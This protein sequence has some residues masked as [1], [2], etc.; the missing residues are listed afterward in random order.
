MDS[1]HITQLAGEGSFGR[2]YK[3]RKKFS[4][5]VVALKFIPK[6]GRSA[7]EIQSLKREIDI[8]RDLHHPNIVQLFDSFETE[9]E[10]VVVTEY[11]EGQ[12]VQILEND[13]CLPESRVREIASQLVS[14]L[15]YL[16]SHRILH[17]DMKPQNILLSKNGVVKLCDF[18]F[19]RSMSVSTW[20]LTSI[21][22]T[23]LYMAPELVEEKPYDHTA[24]LWA[25]GCILYELHTG[26]PPFQT[27]SF[28]HL[29]QL[30]VKGSVKWVDNMSDNCK[31][32]LQGLL[33][34]D[35]EKR[36]SWPTLLHH[37][38]VADDIVVV[39]TE[40]SVS[41][42]LTVTPT[43]HMMELKQKQMTALTVPKTGE[44]KLLRKTREMRAMCRA[45]EPDRSVADKP[46]KQENVESIKPA[47]S[48]ASST[49]SDFCDTSIISVM[50]ADSLNAQSRQCQTPKNRGQIS[51]D[52]EREF[53]THQVC[54][55]RE[56]RATS[57]LLQD[58]DSE[59]ELESVASEPESRSRQEQS[60]GSHM[61]HKLKSDVALFRSQLSAGDLEAAVHFDQTLKVLQELMER[62]EGETWR[63]ICSDF[64]LPDLFF[65]LA[66]DCVE[67]PR[68][69][70]QPW[71]TRVLGELI[72][73]IHVYWDKERFSVEDVQRREKFTGPFC[74]I[75]HQSDFSSLAPHAASVLSLFSHHSSHVKVAS[76][77]SSIRSCG[78]DSCKPSSQLPAGWAL[79]D[80]LLSLLAQT[81]SKD[82]N[83]LPGS[84]PLLFVDLWET[85]STFLE[86]AD[87]DLISGNGLHSFLSASLRVLSKDPDVC[88]A[89]FSERGSKCV[90]TLGQLL[91][92]D[93]LHRVV[94]F[95]SGRLNEDLTPSSYLE[96]TCTLLML[97]FALEVPSASMSRILESYCSSGVMTGLLQVISA[98]PPPLLWL[99][100]SLMS[101]LLM[102]DPEH[103][104]SCL[105]ADTC[106]F[107]SAPREGSRTAC[108]LLSD[109]L[110]K[111][112][113]W[114]SAAELL[115]LLYLVSL[116]SP[117][118]TRL[119][120]ETNDLLLSLTHQCDQI[121]LAACRLLGQ[122]A[123]IPVPVLPTLDVFKSLIDRLHDPHIPVRRSAGLAV[124]NWLV[125]IGKRTE[126]PQQE[127]G[128]AF[129]CGEPD[130]WRMWIEEARRMPA[131]L[132]KQITDPDPDT[133]RYAW[134]TL[135]RLVRDDFTAT[136]LVKENLLPALVGV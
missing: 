113:L 125:Y 94:R 7:Q 24:D 100:L 98:L 50:T 87:A 81:L 32:F 20:V 60:P 54:V 130:E 34:K 58:V 91:D 111:R 68:F 77:I 90:H 29:V 75:L 107:L 30:I 126:E 85:I 136:I 3:G 17:R 119:H 127:K 71:S 93:C 116:F 56:Q 117:Q 37:S 31:S 92:T 135:T 38:F 35:P 27:K 74:K 42:P 51:V 96:L 5:Q 109:C 10:V 53:V 67:S 18:G 63:H 2:V 103:S 82:D 40:Q 9:S 104:I 46:R 80:G 99:P 64:H 22:G 39:K 89:L 47:M 112:D 36:L 128:E 13:G 45:R 95:G 84:D 102:C 134:A 62:S 78:V 11:A 114:E 33:T 124:G 41:N 43:A 101:R 97:P 19:A 48:T 115:T 21:K 6:L 23:P 105:A 1:Y 108:S 110:L 49:D 61:I 55:A 4:G 76:L 25:L 65:E 72:V 129:S 15:Y 83:W 59:E 106:A 86:T 79:C 132:A 118:P 16:H 28:V 88:I 121:R 52:Y 123:V 131:M 66:H 69:T 73:G 44:G 12:L 14:A 57:S 120:L 133:R 70:K 8:M 122:L 26:A